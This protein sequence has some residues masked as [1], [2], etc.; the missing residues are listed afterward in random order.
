MTRLP[1]Q[2]SVEGKV[3]QRLRD[4]KVNVSEMVNRILTHLYDCES[5]SVEAL[6]LAMM[7]SERDTFLN[8]IKHHEMQIDAIHESIRQVD[9]KIAAQQGVLAEMRKSE[10]IA[11]YIKSLNE[12]LES[13]N[14]DFE[15]AWKLPI[16]ESLRQ[17][18]LLINEAWLKRHIA[19]IDLLGR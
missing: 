6:A 2:V 3:L 19:R 4:K 15:V 18:G 14:F 17:E 8:L 9:V 16:L 5:Y 12:E 13:C 11:T 10:R 7:Q 1:V